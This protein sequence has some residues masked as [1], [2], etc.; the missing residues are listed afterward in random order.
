MRCS[1]RLRPPRLS[2]PRPFGRLQREEGQEGEEDWLAQLP[3]TRS[4]T[5]S[6]SSL[7]QHFIQ[8]IQD[9]IQDG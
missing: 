5:P 7:Y 8:P 2:A 4:W 3:W 6:G 1:P 9:A